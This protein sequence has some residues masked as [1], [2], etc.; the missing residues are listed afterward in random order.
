[1][2]S[3]VLLNMVILTLRD[4]AEA[5]RRLL[6]MRLG[7]DV[8]WLAFFLAVILNAMVQSA[9]GFVLPLISPDV[10]Q[11]AEPLSRTL[12]VSV[13]AI[14]ISVMTFL[15]VG[16][17]LGGT[18]TFNDIM[19]L[20]VWLQILQ[21]VGQAIV[22]VLVAI[23]PFLFL[24]A[25]LAMLALSLYITL[26]FLNEAHRFASLGKSFL[27]ILLSALVAIPFVLWLSPSGPV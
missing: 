12:F 1:M 14:L 3:A 9:S 27:V 20:I 22:L 17:T 13:A 11:L 10:Q 7:A 8:L 26:H 25:S 5:A 21:I 18:G 16:R 24:P 2:S 15:L 6:A 4:P 19:T 23:V